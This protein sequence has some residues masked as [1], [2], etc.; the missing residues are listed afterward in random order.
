MESAASGLLAARAALAYCQSSHYTPPPPETMCGALNRYMVAANQNYQ[1]MGANMGL[2]P[3]LA[4]HVKGKQLRY[5][6]L[7]QRALA[8]MEKALPE[9]Q[10]QL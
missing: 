5:A 2:L 3:P 9:F 10:Q 1:P 6:A 7:A 4:E 8:S